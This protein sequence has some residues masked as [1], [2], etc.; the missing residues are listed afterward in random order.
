MQPRSFIQATPSFSRKGRLRDTASR[1]AASLTGAGSSAR[2]AALM[3]PRQNRVAK[4]TRVIIDLT[5]LMVAPPSQKIVDGAAKSPRL[6]IKRLLLQSTA[7]RRDCEST[8]GTCLWRFLGWPDDYSRA[9]FWR[10]GST[11][12]RWR[13]AR[14]SRS[15][16]QAHRGKELLAISCRPQ[17]L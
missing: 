7:I 10:T 13:E 15:A 8:F 6:A 17:F 1:T 9:R 16:K 11:F 3:E 4:I 14:Q 2:T 12:V 5:R